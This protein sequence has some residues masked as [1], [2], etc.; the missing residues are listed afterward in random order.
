MDWVLRPKEIKVTAMLW[1]YMSKT[2]N[3]KNLK[4]LDIN[5]IQIVESVN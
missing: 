3:D 4:L 5:D 1:D 2:D